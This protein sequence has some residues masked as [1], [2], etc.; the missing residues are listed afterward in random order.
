MR[1]HSAHPM[2][3]AGYCELLAWGAIIAPGSF[4][5][6]GRA[7]FEA[8]LSALDAHRAHMWLHGRACNVFRHLAAHVDEPLMMLALRA[9]MRLVSSAD[10]DGA[11]LGSA[12]QFLASV[13]ME[14]NGT[15]FAAQAGSMGAIEALVEIV[16]T[17]WHCSDAVL[18][19]MRALENLAK[20]DAG[21]TARALLAGA[22][23]VLSTVLRM[24]R[25]CIAMQHFGATLAEFLQQ[26]SAAAAV[27]ADAAAAA[28][29]QA[30]IAAAAAAAD[31]AMAALL[32]EEAAECASKPAAAAAGRKGKSKSKMKQGGAG[33]TAA[34]ST[35]GDASGGDAAAD[36][37]AAAPADAEDDAAV[38]ALQA[39]SVASAAPPRSAE[40]ERRRRRA[41]T[42]A[43]WRS[44]AA[45]ASASSV[46]ADAA[47]SGGGAGAS[48]DALPAS[49][50]P[51]PPPPPCDD[52]APRAEAAA[53]AGSAAAAAVSAPRTAAPRAYCPPMG[54]APGLLPE[55]GVSWRAAE[56]DAAPPLP[57]YL[58]ALSLHAP[59]AP[60]PPAP[61]A[62]LPPLPPP[63]PPP[64]P[65]PQEPVP[66]PP[67]PLPLPPS[68]A[69]A[70]AAASPPAPV[71][72]ECCICFLDVLAA[73]VRVLYPC[74]HR[75]LCGGFATALLARPP[76]RRACPICSKEAL[77]AMVV[78][79]TAF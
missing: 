51:L 38:D 32:A 17:R 46:D 69:A 7:A 2:L 16:R 53:A 64:P 60:P 14:P 36:D 13:A 28:Q 68:A 50:P 67:P 10:A 59:P 44:G 65:L 55:G 77:G 11:A 54:P 58:A 6:A 30:D 3:L 22:P 74:G 25:N 35:A 63:P 39:P 24:Q 61:P 52:A 15:A 56:G 48:S 37:A 26:A 72:R 9:V 43:A 40:A 49:L 27:A 62:A 12:A 79:D 21:N 70:P 71:M 20:R 47:P 33:A 73:D 29:R 41:A 4:G 31:A 23:S 45:S 57:S 19:S 75:C 66:P 76:G 1:A 8:A 34:P 18:P 78:F 42:K 5:T